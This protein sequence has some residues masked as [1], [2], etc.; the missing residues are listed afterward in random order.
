MTGLT[1]WLHAQLDAEE[2][3]TR[4]LLRHAQDAHL[5]I[6]EPRLLG[7]IIPGWHSWPDVERLC[8]RH[9]DGIDADRRIIALHTGAHECTTYDHNGEVG[10]CT[11]VVDSDD[12]STARLLALPL[13][14]RPGY[15]DTWKP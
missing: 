3:D 2:A 11:W 4:N 8:Q 7:R 15:Q 9:L 6:Q 5:A 14:H 10:N 13:A 12:C 1:V